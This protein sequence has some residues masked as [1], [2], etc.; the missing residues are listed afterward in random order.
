MHITARTMNQQTHLACTTEPGSSRDGQPVD[1]DAPDH[2]VLRRDVEMLS[3]EF[4][5]DENPNF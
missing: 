1:V 2:V 5:V 4:E 3:G